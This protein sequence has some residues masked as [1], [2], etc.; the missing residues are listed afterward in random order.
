MLSITR[1]SLRVPVAYQHVLC[2]GG[3]RG[4]V[5]LTLCLGLPDSVA[6][7]D[8]ILYLTFTLV[9]F[10]IIVQGLTMTPLLRNLGLIAGKSVEQ[11][12]FR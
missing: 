12:S 10:S 8:E 4:T 7:H 6:L 3:L 5:A 1:S 2:W 11:G 9:G